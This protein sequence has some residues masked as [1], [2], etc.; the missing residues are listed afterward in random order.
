MSEDELYFSEHSNLL[1]ETPASSSNDFT[2][3]TGQEDLEQEYIYDYE[4]QTSEY[5]MYEEE[6]QQDV[7]EIPYIIPTKPTKKVVWKRPKGY[8]YEVTRL[9]KRRAAD[10]DIEEPPPLDFHGFERTTTTAADDDSLPPPSKQPNNKVTDKSVVN[11][12][13]QDIRKRSETFKSKK[14]KEN[15]DDDDIFERL[16]QTGNCDIQNRQ[17]IHPTCNRRFLS[18]EVLAY[19]IS[20][21]H[22]HYSGK[23]SGTQICLVCGKTFSTGQGKLSHM[24]S[25]HKELADEHGR[26]CLLQGP[27]TIVF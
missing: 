16:E 19:H 13:L 14:A 17:C 8:N 23:R 10:E 24:T 12:Y 26:L 6:Q 22:Q 11:F 3:E 15:N 7:E 9:L 1:P 5:I 2:Y 20:Y 21:A 27:N 4:Y 18:I 25:A